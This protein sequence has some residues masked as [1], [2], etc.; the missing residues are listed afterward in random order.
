MA[1]LNAFAWMAL[2]FQFCAYYLVPVAIWMFLTRKLQVSWRFV[3]LGSLTWLTALPFIILVPLGASMLLGNGDTS[4]MAIIWGTALAVTAGI[5]EETS[6]YFYYRRSATL[7][8]PANLRAA[9][10]A[11]AGHGGTEALVLGI[12]YV[13]APLALLLFAAQLLPPYMQDSSAVATYVMIGGFSRIMFIV[14]HIGFTLLVWR[15]ASQRKPLYYVAA[16]VLHIVIDLL[17]FVTP[18]LIPGSD[19][20]LLIPTLP[21]AG[22]AIYTIVRA[23]RGQRADSPVPQ[24]TG[25]STPHSGD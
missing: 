25:F 6:R 20:L 15:A 21:L 2:A 11:G 14:A 18:I 8:D 24:P 13:L 19:L 5:A 17:G 4:R 1:S 23:V 10:V 3:G 22:W 7:R 16:V 12:Q 9:I